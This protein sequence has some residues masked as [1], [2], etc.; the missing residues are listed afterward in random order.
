MVTAAVLTVAALVAS[1][2]VGIFFIP[3]DVL[4]WARQ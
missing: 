4:A 2:S 3:T 1:A